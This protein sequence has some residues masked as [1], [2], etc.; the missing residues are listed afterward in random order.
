M[1]RKLS[2]SAFVSG[3][4]LACAV[5]AASIFAPAVHADVKTKEKSQVKFEGMLGRLAGMAG[6]SAAKDGITNTV[7]VKGHRMATFNDQ[8]GMIVDLSEEKVYNVDVKKKEYRVMT[9]AEMRAQMEKMRAD[10]EKQMKDMPPEMRDTQ[11]PAS[12]LEVTFDVQPGNEPKTIAGHQAKH[13]VITVTAKEKGKTLEEGGG[14]VI[15]ND[16]WLGPRIAALNEIAQFNLKYATSVYGESMAAMGQ[17]FAS[18]GAMYPGLAN[19]MKKM[20]EQ[21]GKLDGTPLMT[22]QR[23]ETVKSAAA[24]SQAQAPPSGG[25]GLGGMLG[26]K[27][28][29][30]KGKP[31]QRG[32]LYTST[33]ETLSIDTSATDA[34]VAIP[35]GFKEKK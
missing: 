27:I 23:T 19:M 7:A 8:F 15:T 5:V 17:Q 6:G 16:V 34:D 31:E 18:L 20:G 11:Q 26:R 14:M 25:G 2:R 9:F 30:N 21:L 12:N 29:G 3:G 10:M 13:M 22:I 24:M 4:V 28:M 1:S 35:A 32:L 33:S